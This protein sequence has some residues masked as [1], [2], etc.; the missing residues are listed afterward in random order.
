MLEVQNLV[1]QFTFSLGR[2]R[3][4]RKMKAGKPKAQYIDRLLF[5]RAISNTAVFAFTAV[6][7]RVGTVSVAGYTKVQ[8]QVVLLWVAFFEM[9]HHHARVFHIPLRITPVPPDIILDRTRD[10]TF[11]FLHK[12]EL[13]LH[14]RL[15]VGNGQYIRRLKHGG[16]DKEER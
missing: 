7:L 16:E 5:M 12:L 14:N 8:F 1:R 3:K 10:L 15:L 11:L 4:L 2:F 9:V 6:L 13:I